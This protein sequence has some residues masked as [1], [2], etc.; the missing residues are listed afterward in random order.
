MPKVNSTSDR[1]RFNVALVRLHKNYGRLHQLLCFTQYVKSIRK[2]K[3]VE[4][5]RVSNVNP[6]KRL[7]AH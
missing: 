2:R 6:S 5:S 3:P 7:K 1:Q 4:S